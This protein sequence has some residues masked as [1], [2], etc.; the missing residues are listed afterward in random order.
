MNE[1]QQWAHK[2]LAALIKKS[3]TYE[4]QAFYRALDQLMTKQSQRLANV[5]GE[6]DGRSWAAKLV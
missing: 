4:D 6:L 3:P 2:E 5:A 1:N